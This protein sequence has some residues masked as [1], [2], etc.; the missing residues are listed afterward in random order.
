[1]KVHAQDEFKLESILE[2]LKTKMVKRLG[3]Q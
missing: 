3:T 1:M 2:I